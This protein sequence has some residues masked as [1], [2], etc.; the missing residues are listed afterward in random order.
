MAEGQDDTERTEDP[1]QKRLDEAHERGD[2]VSS[3]E[4]NTWF[5]IAGGTLLL[6]TFSG[7]MATGVTTTLRGLIANSS[8]IRVD[9][10][11]FI[12]TINQIGF[13]II[14]VVALPLLVLALAAIAGNLIQHRLV[15]SLESLK[16]KLSKISPMAGLGR[17]YSKQSLANVIKGLV[18]LALLGAIMTALLCPERFRLDALVHI[19]PAA[20]MPL[21]LT[22]TLKM[23]GA[24]VAVLALIAAADYLF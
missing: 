4:V 6:M 18:K 9:G 11:G 2:V 17:M 14:S 7:S 12:H 22:L 19:D 24:V 10:R 3:Q 13:E 20:M 1:T 15:W 23:L 21:T 8:S 5:V 16:P